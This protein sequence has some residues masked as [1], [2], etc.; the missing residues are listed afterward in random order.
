MASVNNLPRLASKSSTADIEAVLAIL[1][2]A[3]NNPDLIIAPNVYSFTI[4][5][6]K[7]NSF[8]KSQVA[9][10]FEIFNV[11]TSIGIKLR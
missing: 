2:S 5:E 3:N 8:L 6:M 4:S 11:F 9:K 10:P 7:E 1:N